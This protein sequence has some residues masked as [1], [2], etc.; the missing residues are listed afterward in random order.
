M[1]ATK[2]IGGYVFKK[3]KVVEVDS[4]NVIKKLEAEGGFEFL[5]EDLKDK[6]KKEDIESSDKRKTDKKLGKTKNES[7]KNGKGA[8]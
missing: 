3:G 6:V 4:T 5:A 8:K 1:E 2:C 7:N